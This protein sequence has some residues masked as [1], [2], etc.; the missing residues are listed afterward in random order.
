[1]YLGNYSRRRAKLLFVAWQMPGGLA[2]YALLAGGLE[3]HSATVNI[4]GFSGD[5][6]GSVGAEKA[7]EGGYFFWLA[8]AF[9]RN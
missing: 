2:R 6:A 1:M 7:D 3:D 5:E 9:D 8:E 4:Q